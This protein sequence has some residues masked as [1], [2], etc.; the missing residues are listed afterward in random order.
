MP[1]IRN[2][3]LEGWIQHAFDHPDDDPDWHTRPE[4]GYWD[5]DGAIKADHIA[6]TFEHPD[7]YLARFSDQQVETALW[8]IL[9]QGYMTDALAGSV[10]LDAR[11]RLVRSTTELF[12]NL[13]SIRCHGVDFGG[14]MPVYRICYMFWEM[15][16]LAS[17]AQETD[18][19]RLAEEKM[20]VLERILEF[21]EPMCQYSALHGLGHAQSYQPERVAAT[22]D[23]YLERHPA[24][25][26]ELR[27]YALA[28]RK[29]GV[30]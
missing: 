18:E 27:K 20:T 29:G 3:T 13:F 25:D 12:R 15:M 24:P 2:L 28:A 8:F 21:D 4:E 19:A 7:R 9:T 22:I 23:R 14:K 6:A 26:F 1:L 17:K 30:Q 5:D 11:I 10:P 16:P